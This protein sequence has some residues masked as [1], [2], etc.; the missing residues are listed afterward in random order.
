MVV[1]SFKTFPA[2]HRQKQK[3]SKGLEKEQHVEHRGGILYRLLQ[4]IASM[5]NV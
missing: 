4:L 1:Y 2:I 3:S 5:N